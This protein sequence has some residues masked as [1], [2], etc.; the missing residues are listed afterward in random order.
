MFQKCLFFLCRSEHS[1]NWQDLKIFTSRGVYFQK[2]HLEEIAL[3]TA[4]VHIFNL[5][6]GYWTQNKR[7]VWK[8]FSFWTAGSQSILQNGPNLQATNKCIHVHVKED[9]MF[10]F[11]VRTFSTGL[12]SGLYAGKN[13]IV[14][15]SCSKSSSRILWTL[16][17]VWILSMEMKK[18]T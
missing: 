1:A 13:T 18:I 5:I 8:D 14:H 3:A 11:E 12:S 16:E 4:A 9:N 6:S 10:L 2:R 17:L 7:N 15:P